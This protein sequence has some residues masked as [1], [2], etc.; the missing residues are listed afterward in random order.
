MA[1]TQPTLRL[2]KPDEAP[3][4]PPPAPAPTPVFMSSP[5][6]QTFGKLIETIDAT[7]PLRAA[8]LVCWGC[9]LADLASADDGEI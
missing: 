5:A 2:V 6:A 7:V 1:D 9:C 4:S 3:P 8:Y